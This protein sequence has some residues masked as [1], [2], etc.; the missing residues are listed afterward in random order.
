MENKTTDNN[1]NINNHSWDSDWNASDSSRDCSSLGDL[2]DLLHLR[3]VHLTSNTIKPKNKIAQKLVTKN[4]T[5]DTII[6]PSG[7]SIWCGN[8]VSCVVCSF[9]FSLLCWSVIFFT[10]ALKL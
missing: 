9:F 7:K 3:D 10:C 8:V 1:W 2:E 6:Q 4:D 5:N